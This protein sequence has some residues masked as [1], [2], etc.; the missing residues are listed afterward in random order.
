MRPLAGSIGV[1]LARSSASASFGR[2]RETSRS[3]CLR[4]IAKS[5][6]QDSAVQ[7]AGRLWGWSIDRSPFSGPTP[8]MAACIGPVDRSPSRW[9]DGSI[10]WMRPNAL[11]LAYPSQRTK[12]GWNNQ[13]THKDN[14]NADPPQNQN[15]RV[16]QD[17]DNRGPAATAGAAPR[18]TGPAR[19]ARAAGPAGVLRRHQEGRGQRAEAGPCYVLHDACRLSA[20]GR[21]V[22]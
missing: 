6:S 19:A 9:M 4:G 8:L 5:R 2:S 21:P 17:G 20:I 13:H 12:F 18:S 3:A 22:G 16:S 15:R 11:D 7:H 14:P 10:E 1:A